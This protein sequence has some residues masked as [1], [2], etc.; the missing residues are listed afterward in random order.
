MKPPFSFAAFTI[1][2]VRYW[3]VMGRDPF[4]FMNRY[5]AKNLVENVRAEGFTLAGLLLH[6]YTVC[7]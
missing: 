2:T 3:Y 6:V 5:M 1:S 4:T 7:S